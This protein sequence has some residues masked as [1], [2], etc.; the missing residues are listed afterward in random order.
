L[1]PQKSMSMSKQAAKQAPKQAPKPTAKLHQESTVQGA[2][3][4]SEEFF[5]HYKNHFIYGIMGII[6][7]L[8]IGFAWLKFIREPKMEEAMGQMFL[9][10]QAFRQDQFEVALYGDGNVLGFTQI[11]DEY[12]TLAGKA[13]YFYIGVCHLQLGED[14]AAID[15]LRKY[16]TK[17]FIFQA[18][19]YGCMGDAYANLGNLNMAEEYYRKAANYHDNVMAAFY[20]KKAAI[21]CEERGDFDRALQLYQ[22][23]KD[24]Y[25]QTFEAYEADKYISRLQ[26]SAL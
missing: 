5:S 13:I 15:A 25:P 6:I 8:G 23:I 17:E 9:P 20:M 14:Q 10:E 18:R 24:K 22:D 2:L 11:L 21:V 16:S 19:A 3:S 26:Q 7:L 4:K 1:Q 12:G